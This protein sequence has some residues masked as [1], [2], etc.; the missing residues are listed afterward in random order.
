MET[1]KERYDSLIKELD[2]QNGERMSAEDLQKVN[3][4]RLMAI[5]Q[6]IVTISKELDFLRALIDSEKI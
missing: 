5:R 6:H 1:T 4:Y 3:G 2:Y